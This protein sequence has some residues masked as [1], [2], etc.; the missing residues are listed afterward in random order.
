MPN[1]NE[2]NYQVCPIHEI[3]MDE[4]LAIDSRNPDVRLYR[5]P[6]IDHDGEFE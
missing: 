4:L 2:I 3:D 5:C 6:H 1:P